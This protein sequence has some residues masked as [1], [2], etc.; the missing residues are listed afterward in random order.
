MAIMVPAW[1]L[2]GAIKDWQGLGLWHRSMA[3]FLMIPPRGEPEKG[4][5][6]RDIYTSIYDTSTLPVF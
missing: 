2:A 3:I 4:V 1:W 6:C 5:G